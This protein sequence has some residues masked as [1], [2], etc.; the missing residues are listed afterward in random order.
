MI[1]SQQGDEHAE[2]FLVDEAAHTA[3]RVHGIVRIGRAPENTIMITDPTVS[4]LHAEVWKE[5]ALVYL[6]S[7]GSNG[8]RINGNRV[9][10]QWELVEGDRVDVGW[11]SFVYTARA[12]PMGV[13]SASRGIAGAVRPAE[14]APP[15]DAGSVLETRTSP[16]LRTVGSGTRKRVSAIG[17]ALILA[18]LVWAAIAAILLTR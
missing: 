4:R 13:H 8:T 16:A 5:G 17:L 9:P 10:G 18:G 1:D 6:R 3:F 11:T 12:L 2:C 7:L 15:S 14:A